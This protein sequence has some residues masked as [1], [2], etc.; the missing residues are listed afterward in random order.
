MNAADYWGDGGPVD[1]LVR[2][3]KKV[4]HDQQKQTKTAPPAG[5]SGK[6]R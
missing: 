3:L 4:H 1:R 6:S 2:D 5:K